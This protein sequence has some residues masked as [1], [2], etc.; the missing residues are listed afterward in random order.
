VDS[1]LRS[2]NPAAHTFT[3]TY[4]NSAW[5]RCR[6]YLRWTSPWSSPRFAAR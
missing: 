4:P 2:G 3:C 6:R 1:A 5:R